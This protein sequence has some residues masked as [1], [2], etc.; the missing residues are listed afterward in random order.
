MLPG[1]A[2]FVMCSDSRGP[3]GNSA[4]HIFVIKAIL[5]LLKTTIDEVPGMFE[6]TKVGR[7]LSKDDF[8]V[9]EEVLRADLLQ[10]QQELLK[11]NMPVVVIVAGVEGAGKGEVVNRLNKWLDAR[12]MQTFAFWDETDEERE[13]P[14]YWRFWRSLPPRGQISLLFVDFE[15]MLTLDGALVVKFWFHLS[16]KDQKQRLKELSRDDRSK[17]KMHPEKKKFSAQY[18]L[19][20]QVA[21]RVIR[22]TDRGISPWYLV[23][24]TDRRYRDMTVG[25]TL[26]STIRQRLEK[27]DVADAQ[28]AS[29]SPSLPDSNSAQVTVLDLV[30]LDQ[31]L[32]AKTYKAELKN[33][34]EKANRLAW[35]AYNKNRSTV[36]VFEGWDAGGKGGAIRRFTSAIDSRLYRAISVA[37]PTDEEKAHHYLWRFWRHIPRAGYIS[38]YDR[39]WYG[40]VLVERVEGFASEA[41]WH[42]SYSEINQFEEQLV[43]GGAII[44]KFWLHISEDE[45]LSRF[46]D[47]EKVPYKQ[48][49]ITDEDWRNREKWDDYKLAVNEMVVRTST[50]YAPWTLVPGND[51]LFSRVQV[52]KTICDRLEQSLANKDYHHTGYLPCA[53]KK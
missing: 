30:A 45:Q 21:E 29:H 25:R 24:A 33:L 36:M 1:F 18:A 51:K 26:L 41:E 17:W 11:S 38:I 43:E 14:R 16:E 46:K 23:E 20:E 8:K 50:E 3:G 52:L 39:S 53:A 37:A 28:I 6:A 5:P 22:H 44:M 2:A 19:F 4:I 40:R 42:R 35:E 27:P 13:R 31:A 32:D 7:T 10:V 47:R 12:G 48:H 15:R 9:Q 34:Q 49:K